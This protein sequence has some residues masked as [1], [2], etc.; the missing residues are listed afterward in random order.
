ME[1][2]EKLVNDLKDL[3]KRKAAHFVSTMKMLCLI[4]NE[5]ESA[6]FRAK[7]LKEKAI[8]DAEMS[9]LELKLGLRTD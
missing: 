5:K 8:L 7:A 4:S 9:A 1:N 3:F 6:N 2:K